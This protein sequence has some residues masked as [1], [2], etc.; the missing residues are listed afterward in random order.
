MTF[1]QLCFPVAYRSASSS[2][3][4]H[5]SHISGLFPSD[6]AFVLSISLIS[7]L[8][9][10]TTNVALDILLARDFVQIK[11]ARAALPRT[12][13]PENAAS[14]SRGGEVLVK[15]VFGAT[16]VVDGGKKDMV[17]GTSAIARL[18]EG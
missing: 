8:Y 6:P 4:V 7:L 17:V 12:A 2:F 1:S 16:D 10:F 3:S 14:T 5:R 11:Q 13:T 9:S 18:R 15:L